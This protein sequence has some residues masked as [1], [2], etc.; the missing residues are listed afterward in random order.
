MEILNYL[1]GG[2]ILVVI[3]ALSLSRRRPT[4]R[5]ASPD[6]KGGTEPDA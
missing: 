2:A 6:Q 5:R 4:D 3:A 1:F